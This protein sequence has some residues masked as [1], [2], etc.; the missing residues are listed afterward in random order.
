MPLEFSTSGRVE[1]GKLRL[2]NESLYREV[3]GAWPD[4]E[5]I[6]TIAK[7]HATRSN[8][9]NAW[10][11]S[12]IVGLVAEHTGYTP[13][14]IHEIYKSKFLP[15]RLAMLGKNGDLIGEFVV[16]GSTTTLNRI[17]FSEYCEA[18]RAWSREELGV[19]IPDPDSNYWQ[20]GHDGGA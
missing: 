3:I 7:K 1:G 18:I 16:G 17:E 11:W 10:Y 15:K 4:A 6:V 13:E 8:E 19:I 20:K 9:Q 2:R 14:E 5:V 12:Q